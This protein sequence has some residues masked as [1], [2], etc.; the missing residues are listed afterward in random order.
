MI[1]QTAELKHFNC[2]SASE[3]KDVLPIQETPVLIQ[4]NI[5]LHLLQKKV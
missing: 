3:P 5:G 4:E 2:P 1:Q